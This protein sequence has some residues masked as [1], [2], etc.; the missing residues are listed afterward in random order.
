MA[1][2]EKKYVIQ[3]VVTED[4]IKA[5]G[6]DPKKV[7]YQKVGCEYK[8]VH[9]I[10]T[11]NEELYR[12]YMQPIWKEAKRQERQW[13]ADNDYE[14]A[15]VSLDALYEDYQYEAVDY[16]QESALEKLQKEELY[17]KLEKLLN[18]LSEIDRQI[19]EYFKQDKT[20]AEIAKLIGSKRVTVNK[21][22]HRIF[23]RLRDSLEDYR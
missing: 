16:R 20:D 8:L 12:T 22:R 13:K 1:N 3:M 21:K 18:N 14:K 9:L 5:L 11:D 2:Q 10:E 4:D 15:P 19:V 23:S 7:S 6:I 17:K